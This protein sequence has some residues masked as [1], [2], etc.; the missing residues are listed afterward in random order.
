M[1]VYF[2]ALRQFAFVLQEKLVGESWLFS[3]IDDQLIFIFIT[4]FQNREIDREIESDVD[5]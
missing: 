4:L 1:R 3:K 2:F 5:F